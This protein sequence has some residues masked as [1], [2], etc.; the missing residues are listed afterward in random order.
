M[1]AGI[2]PIRANYNETPT[3]EETFLT[4]RHIA[5]SF[6]PEPVI[7]T[8]IGIVITVDEG[9]SHRLDADVDYYIDL[10]KNP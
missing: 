5:R 1:R 2:N 8:V 4:L 3:G 6:E 9:R 10:H 7:V